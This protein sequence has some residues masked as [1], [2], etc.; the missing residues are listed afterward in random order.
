MIIP[1]VNR[2]NPARIRL[3]GRRFPPLLPATSATANML[4]DSG[5]MDRPAPIALYSSTICR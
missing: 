4:S 2:A 3:A 5:A 1:I